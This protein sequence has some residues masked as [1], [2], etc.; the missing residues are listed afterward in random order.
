MKTKNASI[1]FPGV[2]GGLGSWEGVSVWGCVLVVDCVTKGPSARA[3]GSKVSVYAPC[4]WDTSRGERDWPYMIDFGSWVGP[5]HLGLGG[6]YRV[7]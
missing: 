3:D 2:S 7:K 1:V 6:P 5:G 4:T